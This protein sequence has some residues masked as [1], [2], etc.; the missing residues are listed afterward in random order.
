VLEFFCCY[1]DCGRA[2]TYSIN[3]SSKNAARNGKGYSSGNSGCGV[4]RVVLVGMVVVDMAD[5]VDMAAVAAG[6]NNQPTFLGVSKSNSS[7]I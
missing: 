2:L 1:I 6:I 3:K 5:A 7:F 4:W